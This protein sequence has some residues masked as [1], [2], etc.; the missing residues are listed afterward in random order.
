MGTVGY[1][2]PEQVR[3][4][5]ADHRSDI[6]ALGCVLYEML[7]GKRAFPGKTAADVLSAILTKTPASLTERSGR[8]AGRAL[9]NRRAVPGEEPSAALPV[10]SRPGLRAAIAARNRAPRTPSGPPE[11][12]SDD[13]PSVAVLPFANLSADPEQEFFCDGMAEEIINALAQVQGLRVV[14]RTSAFAFKGKHEDIREIGGRLDV[15]AIVE[16][17]VR[18][19]GDR[20]RDHRSAHR[21]GGRLPPLVGAFRPAVWRTSSRSRTRSPSPSSRTSR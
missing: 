9:R 18:K 14:A 5:P 16:G 10:G 11:A 7:S 19:A 4:E 15:G 6:F 20:L 3:G 21:R 12:P 1:M 8:F 17:S 13:R 2:A